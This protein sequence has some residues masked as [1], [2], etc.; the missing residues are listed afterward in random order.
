MMIVNGLLERKVAFRQSGSGNTANRASRNFPR[1]LKLVDGRHSS[2]RASRPE[3][4]VVT[5]GISIHLQR[6]CPR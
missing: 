4:T 6:L 5:E 2:P 3:R 1:R